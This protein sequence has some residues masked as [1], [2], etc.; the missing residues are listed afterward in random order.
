MSDREAEMSLAPQQIRWGCRVYIKYSTDYSP[1][2]YLQDES[3][4]LLA[5][6]RLA[7]DAHTQIIGMVTDALQQ[8]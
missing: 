6:S 2:Q 8:A 3:R 4:N 1:V 7:H 5:L